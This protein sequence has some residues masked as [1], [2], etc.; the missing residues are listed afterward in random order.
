MNLIGLVMDVAIMV[1]VLYP[2][3]VGWF[4]AY[5]YARKLK[6]QGISFHKYWVTYPMYIFLAFG[7]ILDVLFNFTAGSIIFRE[8]P[9]EFF[10]TSR[11]KRWT[12]A[13][14]AD[15][16]QAAADIWKVRIN[17]IEPGHI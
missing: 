12:K 14:P 6:N 3:F 5:A 16:R 13:D 17:K 15:P 11:V 1:F 8:F 7:A 10:F 2:I 4:F 9:K